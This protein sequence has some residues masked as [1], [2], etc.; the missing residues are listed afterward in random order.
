MKITFFA[1]SHVLFSTTI[2]LGTD[3]ETITIEYFKDGFIE[4]IT[5]IIIFHDNQLKR[6]KLHVNEW[7]HD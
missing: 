5:G 1:S 4:E 3:G 7:D 2:V 6:I